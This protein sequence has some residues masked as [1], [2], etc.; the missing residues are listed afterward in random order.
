[1]IFPTTNPGELFAM[2]LIGHALADYALQND[3]MARAKNHR[4]PLP[5]VPPLFP[6]AAHCLIHGGMVW[7]IT[8]SSMLFAFEVGA[9]WAIDRTKCDGHLTFGQDQFL[10]IVCKAAFAF[11]ALA[12]S[13]P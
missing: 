12:W 3:F 10:H 6:M 13:I 1:M 7:A 2:M 4:A 11:A 8:G 5:G 9:H